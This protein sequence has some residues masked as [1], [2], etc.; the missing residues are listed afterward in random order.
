MRRTCAGVCPVFAFC[1]PVLR[2]T[3]VKSANMDKLAQKHVPLRYPAITSNDCTRIVLTGLSHGIDQSCFSLGES[4]STTRRAQSAHTCR[5][6]GVIAQV[7]HATFKTRRARC[8]H[9]RPS[10]EPRCPRVCAPRSPV[11]GEPRSILHAA[12]L[13]R[14][15]I[16]RVRSSTAR[17]HDKRLFCGIQCPR[18]FRISFTADGAK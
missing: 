16:C 6:C 7:L 1:N 17:S 4:L 5:R 11:R 3:L 12:W 14:R 18:S 2:Y 15:G 9:R 13:A 10:V 8:P